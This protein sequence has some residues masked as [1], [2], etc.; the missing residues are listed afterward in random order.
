M[1][2]RF[3]IRIKEIPFL[4]L[5]LYGGL[6]YTFRTVRFFQKQSKQSIRKGLKSGHLFVLFMYP[7]EQVKMNGGINFINYSIICRRKTVR[8]Y[9]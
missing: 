8:L 6:Y 7:E 2:K 5:S 1:L 4:I 3:F 9:Y